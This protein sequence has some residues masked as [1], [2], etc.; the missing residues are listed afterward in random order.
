V[1]RETRYGGAT[2]ILPVDLPRNMPREARY[3][4]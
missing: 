1:L 4:L 3:I 2:L